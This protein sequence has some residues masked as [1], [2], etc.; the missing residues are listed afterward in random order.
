MK[1]IDK[2]QDEMI[3]EE[4]R[5]LRSMVGRS[6]RRERVLR[7]SRLRRQRILPDSRRVTERLP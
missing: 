7:M 6:R 2:T 4:A 3:R 1:L 5:L